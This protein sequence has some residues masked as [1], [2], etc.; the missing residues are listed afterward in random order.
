MWLFGRPI[1][2]EKNRKK[3]KL[4]FKVQGVLRWKILWN[5]NS[6]IAHPKNMLGESGQFGLLGSFQGQINRSKSQNR[7]KKFLRSFFS[8][9]DGYTLKVLSNLVSSLKIL[10]AGRRTLLLFYCFAPPAKNLN[11]WKL[12]LRGTMFNDQCLTLCNPSG[13]DWREMGPATQAMSAPPGRVG[14]PETVPR[15]MQTPQFAF[16]RQIKAGEHPFR[17][18]L[19]QI[20]RLLHLH[21]HLRHHDNQRE[22]HLHPEREFPGDAHQHGQCPVHR[23]E[24]QQW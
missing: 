13:A 19:I 23:G 10:A 6:C 5:W 12:Q 4:Q 8:K 2:L 3:I 24:V 9:N 20:R 7:L 21:R 18:S 14:P 22:L 15:G 16:P 11:K 1:S 17:F